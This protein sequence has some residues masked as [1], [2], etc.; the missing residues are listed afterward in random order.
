MF[1]TIKKYKVAVI[2]I[3]A[4]ALL[5]VF[6]ISRQGGLKTPLPTPTPTPLKLISVFPLEGKQDI[7]FPNIA[8]VFTFS[9]S[10]DQANIIASVDPEISH[11]VTTDATD[12]KV[13]VKPDN[14]WL[15]G[16]KYKITLKVRSNDGQELGPIVHNFEPTMPTD[17]LLTE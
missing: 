17:S 16:T 2:A 10:I 5:I 11:Q 4:V 15:I 12:K 9:T 6:A 8:V 7:T 3:I 13:Y 1:N 14:R